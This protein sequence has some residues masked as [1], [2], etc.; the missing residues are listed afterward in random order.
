MMSMIQFIVLQRYIFPAFPGTEPIKAKPKAK[1]LLF[2]FHINNRLVKIEYGTDPFEEFQTNIARCRKQ[3]QV[4][5]DDNHR[6]RESDAE[7]LAMFSE[8]ESFAFG[9]VLR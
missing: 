7:K 4:F 3:R 6:I 8:E 5:G 2:P 9:V 1:L